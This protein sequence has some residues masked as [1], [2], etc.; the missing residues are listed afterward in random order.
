MNCREFQEIVQELARAR[1]IDA[2][3]VKASLAHA[4]SCAACAERLEEERSLAL[5]LQRLAQSASVQQAPHQLEGV[6]HAVFREQHRAA[7]RVQL[8]RFAW[9]TGAAAAVLAISLSLWHWW[10]GAKH[11]HVNKTP[12]AISA[13]PKPPQER[14]VA[15]VR[16]ETV[17]VARSKRADQKVAR[18][19]QPE[20]FAEGFVPLPYAD[21]YGPLEAGEIV[22]VQLGR[23]ALESLG[24]PV[25]GADAGQQVLADVLIGQ[26]GL[27][28][29]IRFVE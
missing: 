25:A 13:P 5:T 24:L 10:P 19:E 16:E 6:L 12:I 20:A 9:A 22:R 2:I 29:A 14:V 26:D 21:T 1:G 8:W 4:Y 27:P 3:T 17:S 7:R 28:R 18:R 15:S 23:A 11:E